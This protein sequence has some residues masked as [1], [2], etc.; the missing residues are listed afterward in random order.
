MM[1]CFH[2]PYYVQH[3]LNSCGCSDGVIA[4][5]VGGCSCNR[6]SCGNARS[7]YG[8]G[9]ARNNGCSCGSDRGSGC[10]CGNDRSNGCGC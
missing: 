10:N 2:C 8:C 1:R 4:R 6:C 5:N 7:S 3:M 9:N